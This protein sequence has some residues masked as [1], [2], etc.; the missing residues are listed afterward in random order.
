MTRK[1]SGLFKMCPLKPPSTKKSP[2]FS[3]LLWRRRR[4]ARAHFRNLLAALPLLRGEADLESEVVVIGAA[5][6]PQPYSK[7]LPPSFSPNGGND[8]LWG[9]QNFLS[10]RFVSFRKFSEKAT[11]IIPFSVCLGPCPRRS[12]A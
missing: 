12:A 4:H 9:S 2:A 11:R 5:V 3:D 7:L 8:S 6:N 1:R 10:F